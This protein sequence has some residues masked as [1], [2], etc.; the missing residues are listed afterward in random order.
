MPTTMGFGTQSAVRRRTA[1]ALLLAAL[2]PATVVGC[3]GGGP[4]ASVL[5]DF[6]TTQADGKLFVGLRMGPKG[7]PPMKRPSTPR[8][9]PKFG[10]DVGPEAESAFLMGEPLSAAPVAAELTEVRIL[11]TTG[12]GVS[13]N[14]SFEIVQTLSEPLY[15]L[16]SVPDLNAKSA[17]ALAAVEAAAKETY[18]VQGI[19][20]NILWAQRLSNLRSEKAA[21]VA[22]PAGTPC[23]AEGSASMTQKDGKWEVRLWTLHGAKM[24]KPFV[25]PRGALPKDFIVVDP[26]APEK[27]VEEWKARRMEFVSELKKAIGS[28]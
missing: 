26:A 22:Y 17:D 11:K 13:F 27:A 6:F 1:A 7:L 3:G 18:K 5:K 15:T 4:P 12:K 23:V 19:Q 9:T 8:F 14:V 16:E 25:A 21:V 28:R 20:S 24:M 2:L 10:P